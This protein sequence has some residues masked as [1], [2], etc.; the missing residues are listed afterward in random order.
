[1]DNNTNK[2][3]WLSPQDLFNEYG[4]KLS[5]QAKLRMNK[6]IP[7]SKIGAK[8]VRY[9]REKINTWLEAAEVSA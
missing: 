4:L 1:M 2:N 6:K 8:I 9:N 7:Y 3:L 5:T